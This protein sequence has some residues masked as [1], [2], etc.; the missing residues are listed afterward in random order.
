MRYPQLARICKLVS[1]EMDVYSPEFQRAEFLYNSQELCDVDAVC[2]CLDGD[3]LG[4]YAGLTLLRQLRH[5]RIPIVIRMTEGTGLATLLQGQHS[6]KGTFDNLH[7]FRL[8]DR[9]CTPDLLL[10]GTHEILA[11]AV[12]EEYVRHQRHLGETA[13]TNPAL[14]PWDS[15][16]E[17]VKESNRHQVDRIG[18]KLK[19]I[20]C[21]ITSLS[22]WDAASFDLAPDEVERM[23]R[24]EHE[25]WVE[26]RRRDGW[27]YATGPKDPERQTHPDLVPWKDLPESERDKNRN[28]ARELPSFLARAGFQIYRLN[29]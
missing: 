20:G 14:V 19:A 18:I 26:Q 7:A 22:D 2:I 12:H 3:S 15:L 11:Q 4:L 21:G 6:G 5:H 17:Y 16:P 10:G 29:V 27:V 13:Q 23:S 9:T 1:H 28:A 24:L 25:S 8:L